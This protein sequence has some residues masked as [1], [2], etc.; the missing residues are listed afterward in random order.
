MSLI[1]IDAQGLTVREFEE[2]LCD[3]CHNAPLTYFCPACDFKVCSDCLPYAFIRRRKALECKRCGHT[4]KKLD[5]FV[6]PD[7]L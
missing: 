4:D 5:T 7:K 1:N 2:L 6:G 3:R